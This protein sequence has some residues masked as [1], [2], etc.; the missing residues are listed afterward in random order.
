MKMDFWLKD[1]KIVPENREISIGIEDG[2]IVSLK[3]IAPRRAEIMDMKGSV[4][5]PGL[6]DTHV[7][8]RDPGLTYKEDFRTGTI[9]AAVGGFTTVL[10][11][12]NT[13]P[14]TTTPGAF[15]VKLKIAGKKSLVDFGFH[16]GV[17]KLANIK[18]IN[19]LKPAS[20]KIYMDL[21]EENFLREIFSTISKI[22]GNK[23]LISLHCEDKGI[24]TNNTNKLRA[25]KNSRPEIY[26]N[27]RPPL[28][29][30]TAITRVLKIANEF[31]LNIHICHVST[32]KSLELINNAKKQDIKVS[33]E[34]TPHH[35][36]LNSNYLKICGNF[37]K[38]NPPLRDDDN[39]IGMNELSSIDTIGTDHAPHTVPE[40][41]KNVWTA[42]PGI[43]NLETTLSL[44][45]TEINRRNMTF[46]DLKRLLCENPA[47]I[48]HLENKGFIK[49]GMMPTL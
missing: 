12:P 35:L 46:T 21:I 43:P 27:A 36:L 49:K 19:M 26:A 7:H 1:C 48:F 45:L 29:E 33:A 22:S 4:I 28:A 47:T 38:T 6:I 18:K 11:M 41:Q 39:R 10:D 25:K 31:S 34:L 3:K 30:T 2:K 5:L 13:I 32:K 44:L 16:A 8:F 9:A 17:D 23:P 14:P 42:P 24:V 20:F 37:A 40:K 15:Q